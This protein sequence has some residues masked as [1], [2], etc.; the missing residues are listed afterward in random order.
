MEIK[1]KTGVGILRKLE[2]ME[3]Y[4]R[5]IWKTNVEKLEENLKAKNNNFG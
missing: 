4:V 3:K 2:D 1:T 5:E